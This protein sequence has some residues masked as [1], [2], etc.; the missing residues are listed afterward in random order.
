MKNLLWGLVVLGVGAC[1]VSSVEPLSIPLS[2][3]ASP[4]PDAMLAGLKCPSLARIEVAD[5][6]TEKLLGTRIHE[7]KPLKADVTAAGDPSVWAREGVTHFMA[8]DGIKLNSAGPTLVL[9]ID[10]LRTSENIWHRSGYEARIVF[11]AALRS[12][13]G[14]TCWQESV[15]G[16]AGNYGYSGSI[17]NYQETLNSALDEATLHMLNSARFSDALCHCA[18]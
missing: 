14:K 18:D 9:E 6:R 10:A 3:K 16:K 4:N 8:Q 11:D 5:Q 15:E 17:E 13:S 12:A 7:S 2:Y 1:A